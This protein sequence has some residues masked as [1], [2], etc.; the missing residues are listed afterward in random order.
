MSDIRAVV[1][2]TKISEH[3]LNKKRSELLVPGTEP[4]LGDE[5]SRIP[6]MLLQQVASNCK[7]LY[8]AFWVAF[9]G[10][11]GR[12]TPCN[13]LDLKGIPFPCWIFNNYSM[14]VCWIFMSF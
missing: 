13:G 5:A 9:L 10:V 12:D 1:K 11:G 14:N 7:Y 3:E 4:D 6:I 8:I 2:E